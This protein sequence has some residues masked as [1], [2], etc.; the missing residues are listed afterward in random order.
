M[1]DAVLNSRFSTRLLTR[2]EEDIKC[3]CMLEEDISN[4]ACELT[5]FL[6]C[7]YLLHSV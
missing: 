7:P 5:V 4:T 6:F 3:V 2:S 1:S